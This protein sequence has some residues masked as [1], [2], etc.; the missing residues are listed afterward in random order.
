M[1]SLLEKVKLF[2]SYALLPR[3]EAADLNEA[4]DESYAVVEMAG[5]VA[6]L[7]GDPVE[8]LSLPGGPV[9]RLIGAWHKT[10]NILLE[11]GSVDDAPELSNRTSLL[12]VRLIDPVQWHVIVV[13][14]EGGEVP[15][16]K[17]NHGDIVRFGNAVKYV[18][19]VLRNE[20]VDDPLLNP[21]TRLRAMLKCGVDAD[22]SGASTCHSILHDQRD[23]LSFGKLFTYQ[24]ER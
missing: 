2:F 11:A 1:Q 23:L 8:E 19:A 24:W 14:R 16:R 6:G 21:A 12:P 20:P 15:H 13:R 22:F 10:W 17:G 5:D 7:V 18:K 3:L 4:L 9:T